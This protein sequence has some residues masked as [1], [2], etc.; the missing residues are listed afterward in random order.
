MVDVAENNKHPPATIRKRRPHILF[1]W[2]ITSILNAAPLA[3]QFAMR[4]CRSVDRKEGVIWFLVALD[5][6]EISVSEKL[7]S[8]CFY[9]TEQH[10]CCSLSTVARF[11]FPCATA[12]VFI[13][14]PTL[15][16]QS[17][18]IP[19]LYV[20]P[21]WKILILILNKWALRSIWSVACEY[22]FIPFLY[23]HRCPVG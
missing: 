10:L 13:N 18:W 4:V 5:R 21:S 11:I 14:T 12:L 19:S 9:V 2:V 15:P 16:P 8:T 6:S 7:A 22:A 3:A 1:F 20:I 23:R 17:H